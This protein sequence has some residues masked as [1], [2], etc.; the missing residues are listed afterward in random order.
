MIILANFFEAIAIVLD[1]ALTFYMWIVIA[2]AVLS[3]VSPDPYNPIVRFINTATEP[4][5]YQIRK[6][7]PVN[8]GGLDISPIVVIL[9]IIFLQ[10]FVVKSLHGLARTIA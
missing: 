9:V 2:G 4:V 1:Y 6:R 5:F 3:W 10:A 7:L 8:F